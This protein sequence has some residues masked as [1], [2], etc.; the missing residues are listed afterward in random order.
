MIEDLMETERITVSERSLYL[1]YP[2]VS[3]EDIL[4]SFY[5]ELASAARAASSSL[6]PGMR[7]SAEF[8]A[9]ESGG[10]TD[11][12]YNVRVRQY[13]RTVRSLSFTHT[14]KDGVIVGFKKGDVRSYP[15]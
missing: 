13:G 6:P 1:A 3:G 8:T 11:I 9:S 14:W 2:Q 10:M 5:C 7:Y 4:N 12:T 15:Q